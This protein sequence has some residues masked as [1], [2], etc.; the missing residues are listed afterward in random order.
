MLSGSV[1]VKS[2][3]D[4]SGTE[5]FV[6]HEGTKVSIIS[7]LAEWSEVRLADGNIGWLQTST[8]EKI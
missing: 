2:S 7:T 1:S 6:I 5:V 3:P 4:E 8:I